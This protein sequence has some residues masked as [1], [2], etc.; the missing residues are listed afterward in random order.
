MLQSLIYCPHFLQHT[1]QYITL[2]QATGTLCRFLYGALLFYYGVICLV[3]CAID[4]VSTKSSPK[5]S[6]GTL[7]FISDS[8]P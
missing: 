5:Y 6:R 8:C 2:G 7:K 4:S 3:K 1:S